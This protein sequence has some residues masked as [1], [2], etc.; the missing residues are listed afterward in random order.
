MT[1]P[2]LP[3]GLPADHSDAI[4]W[5][6]AAWPAAAV[7]TISQR[8][9]ASTY[10]LSTETASAYLKVLPL[11]QSAQVRRY[12]LLAERFAREMPRL[13]ASD[14]DKAWMLLEA[15]GGTA[16]QGE[17]EEAAEVATALAR[18][19]MKAASDADLLARLQPIRLADA[20]TELLAFL[21]RPAEAWGVAHFVG[22]EAANRYTRLIRSRADL[23]AQLVARAEGLP[24]TV[25]HGD[26]HLGNAARH[27]DGRVVFFDWD[28]LAVGPAGLCLHGLMSGCAV[29]VAL[30]RRMAEGTQ[31]PQTVEGRVIEAYV[32]VLAKGGYAPRAT[33]L[34]ALPGAL[35]AGQMRF[36]ASFGR[37]PGDA[38]VS[39]AAGTLS[40]R[41]SDLLDL[42]DWLASKDPARAIAAADEYEAQAEWARAHRLVQDRL[43]HAPDDAAL[44]RRY[45]RLSERL[46][47][48]DVAE[49]A[50]LELLKLSD[51][52]D[53]A[54]AHALQLRLD[55][56]DMEGCQ[57][58]L[59]TAQARVGDSPTLRA[60]GVRVSQV[61]EC[62][63]L[64]HAPQGW[65]RVPVSDAERERGKLDA[66]THALVLRLFRQ[67]GAVQLDG[68]FSLSEMTRLQQAFERQQAR[69]LNGQLPEDVLHVGNR[70]YM[71]TMTL[72]STFGAPTMVASGLFLP[73]MRELL[74]SECILSA[75]TAVVSLPG[76]AD[77]GAHKDHT[78]LFEEEGWQ[79]GAPTFAAQVILPLLEMNERTGATAVYKGSQGVPLNTALE[80]LP[81]Q[82]PE[83]P[84]GSCLLV[85]Y[86]VVHFGRGNR[87]DQ[88]RPILNL[89]YSRPWF[90]DCRNYH[91]QP[92]LRFAPGYLEEAEE[93]VRPLVA[94][95]DLECKAALRASQSPA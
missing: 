89:V 93:A 28:E 12:A 66:C 32:D 67:Q 90:R 69:Y 20:I 39:A 36:L 10:L 56:L 2:A 43:A 5:A 46:G 86:A 35:C 84:L 64:G 44:I 95:W 8:N 38:D 26:L 34:D 13:L 3:A 11:S 50:W 54:R 24:Q 58:L 88:V 40:Q 60:L 25:S 72:D 68:V 87:S 4:A 81:H 22:P 48:A 57:D 33:L 94:W 45:A 23:L 82:V 27:A 14:P 1:L 52:D 91:L 21:E 19:Q 59:K 55:R 79:E 83:V 73:L 70:R 85:D 65:P 71:L 61:M 77:Q 74:G 47:S 17:P 18:L 42:C 62:L 49:E 53:E 29:A 41:L 76:S 80:E 78:A 75:Y 6:C 37:Y 92:P 30:L 15:H 9:W 51:N 16:F 63:A 31:A 7:H